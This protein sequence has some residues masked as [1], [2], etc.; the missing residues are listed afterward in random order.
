MNKVSDGTRDVSTPPEARSRLQ[1]QGALSMTS[2]VVGRTSELAAIDAFVHEAS[3]GPGVLVLHGPPG[4]GKTTL[5]LAGL[6]SASSLGFRVL[7]SRPTDVEAELP[8]NGVD[9]LLADV[10][11]SV[12]GALPDPQRRALAI[13]LL[14]EEPG[15]QPVQPRAVA[16]AFLNVLRDLAATSPVVVG[17][18][19]IQWMDASSTAT[20]AYAARRLDAGL[21]R[22]LITMRESDD[23]GQHLDL[24]RLLGSAESRRLRVPPLDE[25]DIRHLLSDRLG[26][27]VTRPEAARVHDSARGNPLFALEIAHASSGRGTDGW[28]REDSIS[29]DLTGLIASATSRLTPETQYALAVAA[30]LRGPTLQHIESISGS[31]SESLRPAVDADIVT[32]VG[33]EVLFTH[34]L[35]A[36]AARA[37][38]GSVTL[39]EIHARAAQLLDDPMECARHLALATEGTDIDVAGA[40]EAAAGTGHGRGAL[41]DAAELAGLAWRR[42]PIDRAED[43]VRRRRLEV[44][45]L[46]LAGGDLEHVRALLDDLLAVT[47]DGGARA[48]TLLEVGWLH[49]M[50]ID[51]RTAAELMRRAIDL[52]GDHDVTRMKREAGLTGALDDIG[53][54]YSESLVHGRAELALAERLGD[55]MHV[56][57]ALRGIARN[58]Q[59]V[60]GSMPRTLIE[61]ALALE[62]VVA[63]AGDQHAVAAWPSV[64]YAEMLAWADDHDA[65][66]D[67]WETVLRAAERS[68]EELSV[69][70]I[71]GHMVPTVILAGRWKEARDLA[72]R[73]VDLATAGGLDVC[74]AVLLGGRS[75]ARS[76]LGDAAGAIDDAA[77]ARSLAERTGS[78]P[79]RRLAAWAMGSLHLSQGDPHAAHDELGPAVASVRHA[80]VGEP[81]V[82]RFVADDVEALASMRRSDDARALLK[83][84]RAAAV[85]SRRQTA[86]A[87]AER[88][89]GVLAAVA[90][91]HDAAM[92]ALEA[93]AA[94]AEASGDP[95][96][97]ARSRLLLGAV[98]RRIHRRRDARASTQAAM[99]QFRGLG[100]TLWEARCGVELARISGRRAS[101]ALTAV[102]REVAE[103]VAQ[104]R[105]NRDVAGALFL[106]ERT[107]EGHLSTIYAK[108]GIRSRAGLARGLEH[109]GGPS[110]DRGNG[111]GS[112]G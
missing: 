2:L 14:L 105:S 34:P 102:E 107:I 85:S 109:A 104:G 45:F 72:D 67:R 29:P 71:L 83:W 94:G 4:I 48:R 3:M 33:D 27:P 86:L 58:E 61:R 95:F 49:L 112:L 7:R 6:D 80:G 32:I 17:V 110:P 40:L 38:V 5:W 77:R 96:G 10:D 43:A 55:E 46:L 50:G 16:M 21:V 79:A 42:T 78:S 73:G 36:A 8:Y 87:A 89:D 59:R 62:P 68:G 31:S 13:A 24:T 44:R 103:L 18:D 9:D 26:R 65:A 23:H 99:A 28:L 63:E 66:N 39:R 1:L 12:L 53:D 22:F 100:A 30:V 70:D 52:C 76:L 93:S 60:T 15:D 64:A 92:T 57:T 35:R 91:E 81:G 25:S 56:A 54:D 19:D 84:Y 88:C 90:G 37:L 74:L 111:G 51:A 47:A 41:A 98:Q 101:M 20:L 106:S 97:A 11:T 108:L 82:M 69:V 75:L